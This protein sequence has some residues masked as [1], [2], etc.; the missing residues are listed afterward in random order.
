MKKTGPIFLTIIIMLFVFSTVTYTSCKKDPCE[1]YTC[2][3]NGTCANGNCVCPS[4]YEGV[5]CENVSKAF[6]YFKNNSMYAISISMYDSTKIIK[7]DSS[8]FFAGTYG[9]SQSIYAITVNTSNGNQYGQSIIWSMY[10][11]FPTSGSIIQNLDVS[12]SYF[13][14]QVINTSSSPINSGYVQ[15]SYLSGLYINNTG[16][17]IPVG[18]FYISGVPSITFTSSAGKTW[19]Y[20]NFSL[21]NTPNQVVTLT[22]Y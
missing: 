1:V 22:T 15:G 17:I 18:Y 5:H 2:Q 20:N 7:V 3:H 13:F 14:L 21:P 19:T 10:V 9:T 16:N 4:G 12:S 8:V 6:I 11:T